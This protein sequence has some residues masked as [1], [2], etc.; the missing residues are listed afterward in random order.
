MAK[1]FVSVES[2]TN[3]VSE[4]ISLFDKIL[5]NLTTAKEKIDAQINERKVEIDKLQKE[6]EGLE[7][8]GDKASSITEKI[9]ALLS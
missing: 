6:Q 5:G 7:K 3:E 9:K 4:S 2:L 1:K 8:L